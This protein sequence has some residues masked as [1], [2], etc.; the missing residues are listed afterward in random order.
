MCRR[1]LRMRGVMPEKRGTLQKLHIRERTNSIHTV[2][3]D[4]VQSVT[5]VT[6]IA[7]SPPHRASRLLFLSNDG[8]AFKA[9]S[10]T[11]TSLANAPHRIVPPELS[12]ATERPSVRRSLLRR[13]HL[14]HE[15]LEEK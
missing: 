6:R 8:P 5:W 1:L 7:F 3:N 11:E 9:R 14:L 10:P 13:F 2:D 12:G 15:V 4:R